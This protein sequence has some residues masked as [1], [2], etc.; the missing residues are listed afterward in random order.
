MRAQLAS[1]P[2]LCPPKIPQASKESSMPPDGLNTG[3]YRR[4][5]QM[6]ST[7]LKLS[8]E[9]KVVDIT[10]KTAVSASAQLLEQTARLQSLS[11]ALDKLKGEVAEHVVSYQ[12]GAKASSD[13]ATFP[14]TSFVKAKEEKQEGTVFVGR[15]AIPCTRGQ[16]Q[17]HRLVLSQQQLQ[18][19][20]SLL[21][22]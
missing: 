4:T 20:H 5:D 2:P 10:G 14:V 15:V 21:M 17:V 8:S 22:A 9:V 16:E 13:F 18:K 12:P 19:V 11:D 1:L 3:I 7:L 6:L